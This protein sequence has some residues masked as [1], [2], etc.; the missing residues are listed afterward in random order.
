MHV[1]ISYAKKDSRAL[2]ADL[3]ARISAMPNFSAWMDNEL[4][5]AGSWSA[6]ISNEID[7]CDYFLVLLSPD[8]NRPK[9]ETQDTSFVLNEIA[10]AIAQRKTILVAMVSQTKVPLELADEQYIDFTQDVELGSQKL[11][12]YLANST[13]QAV[14][15]LTAPTSNIQ[16][17]KTIH[18]TTTTSQGENP[19]SKFLQSINQGGKIGFY[20]GISISILGILNPPPGVVRNW[21]VDIASAIFLTLIAMAI[22]QLITW[23]KM[24]FFVKKA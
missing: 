14:P 19:V 11:L 2:A 22:G 13:N 1:F 7:R 16:I 18:V 4:T 15:T 3:E 23:L 9:T 8:V 17:S 5:P 20:V 21:T 24:R 6:Q 10:Y 12:S